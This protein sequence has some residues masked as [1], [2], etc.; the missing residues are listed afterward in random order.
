MT[1]AFKVVMPRKETEAIVFSPGSGENFM[2]EMYQCT[3]Y[4]EWRLILLFFLRG[5]I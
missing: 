2:L 3:Q 4:K 5:I 1:Y